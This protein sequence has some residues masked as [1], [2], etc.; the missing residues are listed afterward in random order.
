MKWCDKMTSNAVNHLLLFLTMFIK[1]L[2]L[3]LAV[4]SAALD[5]LTRYQMLVVLTMILVTLLL[6][7]KNYVVI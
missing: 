1:A 7:L 2:G 6:S 3:A 4:Q 5:L